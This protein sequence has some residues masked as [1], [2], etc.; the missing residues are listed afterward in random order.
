[1]RR[2]HGVSIGNRGTFVVDV[3]GRAVAGRGGLVKAPALL[4]ALI[5]PTA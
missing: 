2:G 5:H 4:L 3:A 1:V